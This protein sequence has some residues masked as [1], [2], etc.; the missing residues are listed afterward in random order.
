ML[1]TAVVPGLEVGIRRLIIM[2]AMLCLEAGK[3]QT[4][5]PTDPQAKFQ[6]PDP[7]VMAHDSWVWNRQ[8]LPIR[9]FRSSLHANAIQEPAVQSTNR[10]WH[11]W[12]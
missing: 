4:G 10:L 7:T 1:A 11:F 5:L 2:A 6:K 12:H 8:L 3:R 9:K